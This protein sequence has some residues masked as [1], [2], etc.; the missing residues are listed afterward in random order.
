M[1]CR[2]ISS[3]F[4]IIFRFIYSC[5]CSIGNLQYLRLPAVKAQYYILY[6]RI[7]GRHL[8]NSTQYDIILHVK[9]PYVRCVILLCARRTHI[10]KS[11]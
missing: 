7:T 6:M 4:I 8:R 10:R 11:I 2:T 9:I 1:N 5:V 3:L